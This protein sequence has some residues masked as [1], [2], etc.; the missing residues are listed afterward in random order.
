MKGNFP[1]ISSERLDLVKL[2]SFG[3]EDMHEYSVQEQFYNYLEFPPHQSIEETKIY[4]NKLLN[5]ASSD[6]VHYWFIKHKADKKIIGSFGIRDIDWRKKI[7]DLSYGISCD[8]TKRGYFTEVLDLVL[9]YLF[10]ELE[11]H[12]VSAITRSDNLGSIKGLIKCGFS[13]EGV[14]RDFYLNPD[15]SRYD[16][17][18]LAILKV[19]YLRK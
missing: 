14:L 7:G 17:T 3:L 1:D 4:L 9:R 10:E 19:D 8:Y 5:R 11:F 2:G 18:L 16:A 6:N 12:R 13:E 15:D